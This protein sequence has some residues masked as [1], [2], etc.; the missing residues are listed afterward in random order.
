MEV[1]R[2][3]RANLPTVFSANTLKQERAA[4]ERPTVVFSVALSITQAGT[5][6]N[7]PGNLE[8]TTLGDWFR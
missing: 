3:S 6:F 2:G 7:I 5:F 4:R 1:A 8:P